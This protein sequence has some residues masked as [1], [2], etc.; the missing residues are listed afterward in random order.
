M[1]DL[2]F[3]ILMVLPPSESNH[4]FNLAYAIR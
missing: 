2:L 1:S 4:L 3:S